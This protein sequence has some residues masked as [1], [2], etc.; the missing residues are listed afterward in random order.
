MHNIIHEKSKHLQYSIIT[1]AQN[2]GLYNESS[3][4][5]Y[6]KS[7]TKRS[8]KPTLNIWVISATQNA[9]SMAVR[10]LESENMGIFSAFQ[11]LI[12]FGKKEYLRT[13]NRQVYSLI[14]YK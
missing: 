6:K 4:Y 12:E 11:S 14:L 8:T 3:N 10:K 7:T 1:K 2:T 13:F 5:T 9:A